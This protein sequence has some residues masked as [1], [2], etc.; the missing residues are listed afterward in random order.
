M[1]IVFWGLLLFFI[2]SFLGFLRALI[3]PSWYYRNAIEAGV[4]P[5]FHS[6]IIIKIVTLIVVGFLLLWSAGRL[7]YL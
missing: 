5:N 6:M 7:G 4:E 2:N 3:Q 1:E